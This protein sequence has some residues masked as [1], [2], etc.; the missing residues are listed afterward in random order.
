[1]SDPVNPLTASPVV[2]RALPHFSG[3]TSLSHL[4]VYN[5]ETPDGLHGGS[6][7]LHTLSTEAYF[8][9]AGRGEVHT[10]S[11]AGP[12][13]DSLVPGALLWFSPGTVHR[14]ATWRG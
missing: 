5:W 3:G 10:I 4:C 12:A 2:D 8:I 9:T 6:P 14:L 7:H 1:M 11:A 13:Q